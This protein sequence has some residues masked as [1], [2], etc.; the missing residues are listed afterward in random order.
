MFF[1]K[2]KYCKSHPRFLQKE[3]WGCTPTF[4]VVCPLCG[5]STETYFDKD[6]AF[7]AWNKENKQYGRVKTV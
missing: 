5:N 6:S 7:N 4:S 2:C 1:C 3:H